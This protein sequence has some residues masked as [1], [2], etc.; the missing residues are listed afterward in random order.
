VKDTR[1]KQ[2]RI[3]RVMT[4]GVREIALFL[5]QGV[6]TGTD[7]RNSLKAADCLSDF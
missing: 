4:D 2:A 6:K 5:L 3:E 1:V 7:G